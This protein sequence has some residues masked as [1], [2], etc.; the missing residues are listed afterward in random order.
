MRMARCTSHPV[1]WLFLSTHLNRVQASSTLNLVEDYVRFILAFFE[2]INISAPHIF[3]SALPLSPRTSITHKMYKT[4]ASPLVRV[5]QGM[6]DSWEQV[7]ATANFH[8]R[9]YDAVWSPCNRFI[10][11]AT[12]RSLELLDAVTLGRLFVFEVPYTALDQQLGFSPDSRFLTLRK[13]KKFISWD[14]QTGG[15]LG[16]IHSY[17]DFPVAEYLLFKP[18]KDG[19]M[20]VVAYK[21]YHDGVHYDT[22][23]YDLLSGERVG[24]CRVPE[25]QMIYPIWTH[26]GYLRF[27]TIDP[28]SIR[29]W[30]SPFSLEHLPVEV[31]S[32]PVPDG[33]IDAKNLLF[34]PSLSRL[35][36]VLGDTI[37]VWDLKAPKLLLKSKLIPKL[38]TGPPQ[39]SFSSDGHFFAYTNTAGGVCVWKDSPTG[40][41]LH[42]RLPFFIPHPSPGPRL[43]PNGESIIIPLNNKILRLHTRDQDP[44]FPSVSTEDS[45]RRT[46][47]LGF[48]ADEKFVAFGQRKENTVTIIDLQSGEPR[49][50]TNV[51]VE[52]DCLGVAGSTVVL[53][54]E[55]KIVSWNLPGGDSASNASINDSI[56][57]TVLRHSSKFHSSGTPTYTS[58]P[59]D[60]SRIMVAR[61]LPIFG[62]SL[63]VYD[64]STGLRLARTTTRNGMRPRFTQDGRE[65]WATYDP[66]REGWEQCEIIEDSESG[67]IELECQSTRGPQSGV[68]RESSRGSVVTGGGWVLSPSQ[69]RLLW[70]PHRWRSGEENRAWGGRFLGLLHGELSEVVVLEFSGDL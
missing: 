65:A 34:L 50:I 26:D 70:L 18:S 28:R 33:V 25:G 22:L 48:S 64:V 27:A 55:E 38:N 60:L 13:D 35:V 37:Q 51:G 56:R 12:C 54:G 7:V 9:L 29:I 11:V 24:S 2:I 10:A 6:P 5:V 4:H 43:S 47:T 8:N 21:S 66:F 45:G 36:F 31:T 17:V 30:Q 20:V 44:S 58:I 16:I 63:E 69:K 68:F 42:Q 1:A 53:V 14:L 39:G 15:Q 59:P 52:I 62:S 32:L 23:V 67:T 3:H 19:K 57:T 49:W 41:L 46:F 40:Y 61:V